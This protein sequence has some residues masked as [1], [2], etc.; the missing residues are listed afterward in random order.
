[1]L[2][3]AEYMPPVSQQDLA[4]A[5]IHQRQETITSIVIVRVNSVGI[6]GDDHRMAPA[7]TLRANAS[8]TAAYSLAERCRSTVLWFAHDV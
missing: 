1:M 7:I 6:P 4:D 3:P 5:T 8:V 2:L